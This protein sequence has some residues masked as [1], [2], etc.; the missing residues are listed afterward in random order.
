M[1][2][3]VNSIWSLFESDSCNRPIPGDSD[4][5]CDSHVVST[6][7]INNTCTRK[8]QRYHSSAVIFNCQKLDITMNS[9]DPHKV[10]CHARVKENESINGSLRGI[11]NSVNKA[12]L[13][14]K[15]QTHTVWQCTLIHTFVYVHKESTAFHIPVFTKQNFL[16]SVMCRQNTEFHS[17]RKIKLQ[18]E[19]RVWYGFLCHNFHESHSQQKTVSISCVKCIKDVKKTSFNLWIR[20]GFGST[21]F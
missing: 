5:L 21:S 19:F 12:C 15:G 11:V 7:T 13:L 3:Y 20:R 8:V 2:I 18:G 14:P 6:N 10:Q 1:Y 9:S 4:F 16:N 17:S